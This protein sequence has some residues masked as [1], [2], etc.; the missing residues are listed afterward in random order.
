MIG[1]IEDAIAKDVDAIAV[2]GSDTKPLIPVLERVIEADIPLVLF[3]APADELEGAYATYIG[4]DNEAGGRA[5]G[6]WLAEEMPGRRRASALVAVRRRRI[7]SR[8]RA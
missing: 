7:R 6:E 3:D 1:L 5:A 2:N 4:T 8:A